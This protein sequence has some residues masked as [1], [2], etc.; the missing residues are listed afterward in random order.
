MRYGK[1]SLSVYMGKSQHIVEFLV[2]EFSD[3][4]VLGITDLQRFG[5]TSLQI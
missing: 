1:I 3:E 4:A 2:G 5:L